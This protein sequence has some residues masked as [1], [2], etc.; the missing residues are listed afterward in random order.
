M[1]VPLTVEPR[2]HVAVLDGEVKVHEHKWVPHCL[3]VKICRTPVLMHVQTCQY[4]Y[5]HRNYH[6]NL[7]LT[8]KKLKPAWWHE[9]GTYL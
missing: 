6:D 8:A 4:R 9:Y 5:V 7:S 2:F 3:P 1:S